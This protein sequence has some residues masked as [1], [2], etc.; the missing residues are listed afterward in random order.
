MGAEADGAE[1]PPGSTSNKP[2]T[3]SSLHTTVFVRG[4]PL[5]ITGPQL[6]V[7]MGVRIDKCVIGNPLGPTS[8][9]L[10]CWGGAYWGING[11]DGMWL[12]LATNFHRPPVRD[13]FTGGGWVRP[14]CTMSGMR[15]TSREGSIRRPRFSLGT[16]GLST[17][18]GEAPGCWACVY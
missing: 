16:R 1:P 10:G 9:R 14:P 15:R 4:L 18:G 6:Q 13:R 11:W 17:R 2:R 3:T 12:V 8:E 5:D 7:T